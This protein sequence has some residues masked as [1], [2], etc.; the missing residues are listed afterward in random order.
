M[1]KA[2][3]RAEA[4]KGPSI[5][6]TRDRGESAGLLAEAFRHHTSGALDKARD[7]YGQILTRTPDHPDALHL[8]GVLCYQAGELASSEEHI[9]RALAVRPRAPEYHCSMGNTLSGMGRH[10][11]AISFYQEAVALKPDYAEACNN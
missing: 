1:T 2:S 10:E 5:D 7:L 3:K 4:G 8:L 6:R 11:E 9:R